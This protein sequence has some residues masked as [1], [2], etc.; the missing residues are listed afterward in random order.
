MH[1]DD[2]RWS[3]RYDGT[4]VDLFDMHDEIAQA[5]AR[6]LATQAPG[7]RPAHREKLENPRAVESYLRARYEVWKFSLAGLQQAERL[8]RNALELVGPNTRLLATLGHTCARYSELGL[9][10]NGE[11]R[12]KA[13][14]CA[15]KIFELDENSSRGYLL[16]GIVQFY[17]GALRAALA[18][19]ERSMETRPTDPDALSLL[20]YLYALSGRNACASQLIDKV[21]DIDPLTPINHFLPGFVAVMEG[22][23]ADALPYYQRFF[24]LDTQNP[25]AAWTWGY[26]LL[27]NGRVDETAEVMRELNNEHAGSVLAQLGAALLHGIRGEPEAARH[28]VTDELRTGGGNSELLSRELTHCLA[29]AGKTDE[30]L[31]WLE[32]TIRIGNINYPFWSQHSDW[33]ASLRT[34]TRLEA[35]MTEME[36]EWKSGVS[37][38]GEHRGKSTVGG[39]KGLR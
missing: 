9:D 38:S 22:R 32:N 6:E 24:D 16:R 14:E 34:D 21:F 35:L 27:R 1:A 10:P 28:A 29:L 23:W 19:L 3:E 12:G 26:V 18:P 36:Q 2:A 25:F 15:E 30:A 11:F 39:E 31:D 5:V 20:G 4:L 7:P 13:A 37:S 33:V 17:S 8:L